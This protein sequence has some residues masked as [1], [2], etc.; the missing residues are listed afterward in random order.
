MVRKLRV[1]RAIVRPDRRDQY[2]ERWAEYQGK[3]AEQGGRAWLFED[4]VLPGRFIEFTEYTGGADTEAG[5]AQA[6]TAAGFAKLCVRRD[7]EGERYRES[8]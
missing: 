4:E 6:M 3:V 2:R 8:S 5:I 7:G 1:V